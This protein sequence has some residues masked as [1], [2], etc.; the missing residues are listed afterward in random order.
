[1]SKFDPVRLTVVLV[2]GRGNSP[3]GNAAGI[4]S[5]W[6][7]RTMVIEPA[8]HQGPAIVA[9]LVEKSAAAPTGKIAASRSWQHPLPA[10]G[11]GRDFAA[12]SMRNAYLKVLS[13]KGQGQHSR[14]S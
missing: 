13:Q 8:D 7:P 9:L 2:K 5:P 3:F 12:V 14:A 10:K 4:R 6:L 11:L 1:M